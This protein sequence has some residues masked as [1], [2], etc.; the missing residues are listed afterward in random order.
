M[1]AWTGGSQALVRTVSR[2]AAGLLACDQI[3]SYIWNP[4]HLV[5]VGTY[6]YVP[7]CTN[8]YYDIVC[9]CTYYLKNVT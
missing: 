8:L 9:T 6:R 7:I 1:G 5:H 4:I 2:A 3:R